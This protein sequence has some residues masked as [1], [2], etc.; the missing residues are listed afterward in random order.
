MKNL[1]QYGKRN[2]G[3]TLL[4]TLIA[5]YIISITMLLLTSSLGILKQ[6]NKDER[7]SDD[8]IA[9]HQLRL[10]LVASKNI[11]IM[12]NELSFEINSEIFYLQFDRNRL[13]KRKGYE[14]YLE[15]VDE[16]HFYEEGECQGI[17]WKRNKKANYA[18]LAC[19]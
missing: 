5:V 7:L 13:V 18:I 15:F 14:I 11:E 4:E 3:F 12:E 16:L 9:I 8:A 17:E 19:S 1:K 6:V 10:L 2:K